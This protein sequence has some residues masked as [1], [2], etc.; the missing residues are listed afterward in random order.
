MS[1]KYFLV[2]IMTIAVMLEFVDHC[3]G[4][5]ACIFHS[6]EKCKKVSLASQWLRPERFLSNRLHTPL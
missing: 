5:Y 2:M 4:R 3:N 1:V 6:W